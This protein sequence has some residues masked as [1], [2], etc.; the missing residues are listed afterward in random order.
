M[1]RYYY[2]S[3]RI[4]GGLNF[5]SDIEKALQILKNSRE[6]NSILANE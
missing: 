6:Y 5:D 2:Q 4:R 3:G 1:S